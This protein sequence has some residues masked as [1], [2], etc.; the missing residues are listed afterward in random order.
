MGSP[1]LIPEIKVF[2]ISGIPI[3]LAAD[4]AY[5]RFEVKDGCTKDVYAKE[6]GLAK[7]LF[8]R[9]TIDVYSGGV[10]NGMLALDCFAPLEELT[11]G[12]SKSLHKATTNAFPRTMANAS[13]RGSHIK[14]LV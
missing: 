9:E 2:T 5:L 11:Q 1:S 14:Y 6:S 3:G 7:Y 4:H 12:L 10:Y 8:T 13:K